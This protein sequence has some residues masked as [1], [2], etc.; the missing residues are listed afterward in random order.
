MENHNHRTQGEQCISF[1]AEK[2]NAKKKGVCLE[3]MEE[4]NLH[5]YLIF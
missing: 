1:P 4:E 2:E 3:R 5:L